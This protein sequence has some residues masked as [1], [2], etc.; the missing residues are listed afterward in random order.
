MSWPFGLN[1][2]G[3]VSGSFLKIMLTICKHML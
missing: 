1:R 3:A 2:H